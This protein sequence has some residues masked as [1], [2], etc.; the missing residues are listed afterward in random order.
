MEIKPGRPRLEVNFELGV[1][2][3]NGWLAVGKLG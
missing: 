1:C 3:G 2:P